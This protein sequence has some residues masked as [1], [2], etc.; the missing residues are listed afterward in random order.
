MNTFS[1]GVNRGDGLFYPSDIGTAFG[2]G[3]EQKFDQVAYWRVAEN[4][5]SL[6]S[7]GHDPL[8]VLID[9]AHHHGMEFIASLRMGGFDGLLPTQ[10]ADEI[11]QSTPS[12]PSQLATSEGG[13][14]LLDPRAQCHQL[15]ILEELVTRYNSDGVELDFA[16]APGGGAA[17]FQPEDAVHGAPVLTELMRRNAEL[18]HS[19]GKIIG[20]RI[21]PTEEMNERAGLDVRSWISEGLVDY[22]IPMLYVCMVLDTQGGSA[23]DWLVRHAHANDVEVISMLQPYYSD[24][25]HM[26]SRNRLNPENSTKAMRHAAAAAA[27]AKG[28]TGLCV[29]FLP[30]P[31]GADERDSLRTIA[32]PDHALLTADK[33]YFARWHMCEPDSVRSNMGT[34]ASL[35]GIEWD[36]MYPAELPVRL[37]SGDSASVELFIADDIG[38]APSTSTL[39]AVVLRIGLHG[40]T[41]RDEMT[42]SLNGV[43]VNPQQW[44]RRPY[45]GCDP[46]VAQM[47]EVGAVPRRLLKTGANSVH[48]GLSNR[49]QGLE[50]A[51]VVVCDVELKLEYNVWSA[52][53]SL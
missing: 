4:M 16:C 31:L 37:N 8:G 19:R 17:V 5:R 24:T 35:E 53:S 10:P 22:V 25:T 46:Y 23:A 21:Y 26:L 47:I 36:A 39:G 18:C 52:T 42:I 38:D 45:P 29:W 28:A 9:R 30:W 20:A 2:G 48:I 50:L 32:D 3:A 34:E 27:Y 49:P 13:K 44:R 11:G 6:L 33:H 14:G 15:A 1:Y 7:T 41:N 40:T 12:G 43:P 51:A